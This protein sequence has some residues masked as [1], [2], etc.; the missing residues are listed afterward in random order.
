MLKSFSYISDTIKIALHLKYEI[1]IYM[2][3]KDIPN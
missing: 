2:K 1:N 3:D